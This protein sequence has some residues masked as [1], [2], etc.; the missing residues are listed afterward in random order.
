M[1]NKKVQMCD[2]KVRMTKHLKEQIKKE[3]KAMH[4]SMSTWMMVLATNAV[5]KGAQK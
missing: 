5:K 3:A 2:L 4:M 1:K